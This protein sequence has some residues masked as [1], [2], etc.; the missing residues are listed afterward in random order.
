M[1]GKIRCIV[2]DDEAPARDE[3]CFLISKYEDFEVVGEADTAQKAMALI[4]RLRPEVVFLDIQMPREDGFSVVEAISDKKKSPIFVFVTAYD[5]YAVKAFEANAVDY[6]LKPLSEKRF[7]QTIERIR[8]YLKREDSCTIQE[9]VHTILKNVIPEVREKRLPKIVVEQNGRM[10]FVALDEIVFFKYKNGRI[11]VHTIDD[12]MPL[13]SISTMDGLER[14][15]EGLQF[16]RVHRSILVNLD[17]IREFS[18][19]FNGKYLLVMNDI[20]NSELTVSKARVSEFK[21]KIGI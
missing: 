4:K 8:L 2:V 18:P 9:Q 3:L 21:R 13:H 14:H 16:F 7:K 15:L 20:K 12:V 6:L 10:H 5:T 1:Y 19:W 11:M 17:H